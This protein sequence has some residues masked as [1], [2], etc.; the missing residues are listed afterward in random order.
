MMTREDDMSHEYRA[1]AGG[2]EW[3]VQ[4]Q[5]D[6]SLPPDA[7]ECPLCEYREYSA[8]CGHEWGVIRQPDGTLPPKADVCPLCDAVAD[9][10]GQ[11]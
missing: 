1:C 2:H 3:G 10:V 4:R 6:G 11:A 9:V 8:D 5:P 7:D